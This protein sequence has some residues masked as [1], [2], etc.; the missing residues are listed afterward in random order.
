ME[1]NLRV[2]ILAAGSS[3][4]MG[5]PKQLMP[6]KGRSLIMH[7]VMIANEIKTGPPVV[8]T[9]A[10]DEL[11]RKE[12]GAS[13][14]EL[15]YNA[16]WESGMASSV[17]T[18]LH[19]IAKDPEVKAVLMMVSDQPFVSADLLSSMIRLSMQSA[20]PVVACRYKDGTVGTPA[21][22][23]NTMFSELLNL[24][25][26]EG[27]RIILRNHPELVDTIEFPS[28]GIDIDTVEDYNNLVG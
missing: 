3:Q 26:H 25:G 7:S 6:Y 28:G 4:R 16:G 17:I 23:N 10:Y 22:F 2:V 20:K 24:S 18:G 8:V 1:F 13:N 21:I 11:I 12:L 15:V 19:F 27:P 14:A 5:Q 9:G